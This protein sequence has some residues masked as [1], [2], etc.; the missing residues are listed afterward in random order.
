MTVAN[1][2]PWLFLEADST[3]RY[4]YIYTYILKDILFNQ[5]SSQGRI[6]LREKNYDVPYLFTYIRVHYVLLY[7][8]EQVIN[9]MYSMTLF[10]LINTYINAC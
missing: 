4:I 3:L 2:L 7:E 10:F 6:F 9:S 1:K 5:D 8:K